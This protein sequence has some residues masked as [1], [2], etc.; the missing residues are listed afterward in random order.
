M[1]SN[2]R[3][4]DRL[5]AALVNGRY[6]VT[7]WDVNLADPRMTAA[8]LATLAALVSVG[9]QCGWCAQA[10]RCARGVR[11]TVR[12]LQA[13]RVMNVPQM[14]RLQYLMRSRHGRPERFRALPSDHENERDSDSTCMSDDSATEECGSKT[15]ATQA[16]D[17]YIIFI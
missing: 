15:H 3:P 8:V 1:L 12:A 17:E 7:Q 5:L 9:L 16:I 14:R 10:R 6:M 4:T 2:L 11:G 13:D